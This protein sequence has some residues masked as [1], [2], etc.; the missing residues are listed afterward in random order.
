MDKAAL[1]ALAGKVEVA[2]GPDRELDAAIEKLLPCSA[3]FA[4]HHPGKSL[5]R[6]NENAF[7]FFNIGD[8]GREYQSPPFTASIDAA[9]TLVTES[10]CLEMERVPEAEMPCSATIQFVHMG[11]AQTM[12]L[13]ICSAALRAIAG[14]E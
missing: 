3:S 14:G 1:I 7:R 11:Q 2:S 12:P 6:W 10:V 8:E 9:M 13:A 5:S 4:K